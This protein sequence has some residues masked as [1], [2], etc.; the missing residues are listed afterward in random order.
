LTAPPAPAPAAEESL[1]ERL[2][3]LPKTELH[4][5]ALGALRPATLVEWARRDG[6]PLLPSA[7]SLLAGRGLPFSRLSEFVDFFIGLFGLVRTPADF[8]RATYEALEDAAL[9]GVRYA[10]L[11]WT[12][13]SHVARGATVDGMF[14]GLEAGRR[15][16]EARHGVLARWIV[17]F[18]RSLALS[19]AEEAVSIAIATRDRGTVAVD[20]SG[21]ESAVGADPSFAPLFRRARE[22]GLAVTAHAG[23]G[24]G[25][26]SVRGS[27]DLYGASRVGHGT[28]AVEDRDVVERLAR[29]RVCVEVCPTSNVA[30][31]VVRSVAEH[32]VR[33]FLEA[34]VAVAVSSDDPTLFGT[35]VVAE[36][37][38]LH[39]EA[40][41]PLAVLGGLAAESFRHAFVRDPEARARLA[42]ASAEARRWAEAVGAAPAVPAAS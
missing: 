36:H 21:D 6:S 22:S 13:T 41:I 39:R 4:L 17:D 16:A 2:R 26:E 9:H 14:A 28:R 32:P 23:E 37:E 18:P 12:P 27:L 35:D 15:A 19:V 7:E 33:A 40:G 20:V 38:R 31:G 24:A 25:P 29:E 8:E 42:Q 10:E 30:L 11:R 34:G 3:A 5:H 1:R